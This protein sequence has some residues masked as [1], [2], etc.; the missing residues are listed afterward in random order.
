MKKK[1]LSAVLCVA[2]T[3]TMVVGC[4]NSNNSNS[5]DSNAADN[6]AAA[7]TTETEAKAA[8]PVATDETVALTLW[9]AEDDQSMLQEMV[10]SFEAANPDQK[11]DI[12][13]GVQSESTAKDTVLTDIEAAAD[14][15]AFADDQ[16]NE[17]VNA[18]ALQAVQDIDTISSDNSEGSVEAATLD[19]KLYAYPYTADNGYFMMYNKQYLKDTDITSLDQILKV[20]ADNGKSVAMDWSS[21]WYIYSF[22]GGAGLDVSLNDDGVTT[23]CNWNATDTKIKGADV[24]QAMLDIS[25]SGG[26]KSMTDSEIQTGMADG[27]VIAAVEGTWAGEAAKAAWGDNYA[28][29]KLPTYTCAGDQV[30]MSSFAGY[31]LLGVNAYSKNVGW[32]M[33]L[34]KWITNEDNQTLHFTEKGMGPSNIK[35]ASSDA[36]KQSVAINAL[37]EQSDYATLQRVGANY[38]DPVATFGAIMVDG[39]SDN[40][41]LQTLLDNTVAGV[42]ADVVE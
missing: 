36:V 21:A 34:A 2:M 40:Q 28:A 15:F 14:V 23:A 24:A 13:I 41:D 32:A 18:G 38:W 12:T 4:G 29:C 1:L 9:G 42:T 22:F 7:A 3:A 10:D 27:S 6:S 25:K 30:Q 16:L 8:G 26:F 20:A 19:E 17:L 37:I 31:K 35:A 33:E 5:A 39:N 11:F